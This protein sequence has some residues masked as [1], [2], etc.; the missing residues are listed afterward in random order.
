VEGLKVRLETADEVSMKVTIP[1]KE[2]PEEYFRVCWRILVLNGKH[3]KTDP[4]EPGF[5]RK[6]VLW[7][8]DKDGTY[9]YKEDLR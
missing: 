9:V 7:T 2:P 3:R 1:F 4:L 5:R 8:Q 6:Y